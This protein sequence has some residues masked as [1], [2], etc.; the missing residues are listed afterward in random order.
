MLRET[1][2]DRPALHSDLATRRNPNPPR[3]A[4]IGQLVQGARNRT[5]RLS[6]RK[7]TRVSSALIG[8]TTALQ[9]SVHP[10]G[11]GRTPRPLW[12][13]ADGAV[14]PVQ[15]LEEVRLPLLG[16]PN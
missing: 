11:S 15:R 7:G 9:G 5:N 3:T 1:R 4:T 6:L 8:L 10:T 2:P 16:R 13:S 12:Q 14:R